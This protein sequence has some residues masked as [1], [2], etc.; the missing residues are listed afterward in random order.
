MA[1]SRGQSKK[2]GNRKP[3]HENGEGSDQEKITST[4]TVKRSKKNSGP[5]EPKIAKTNSDTT[6]R[7]HD[8]PP[9]DFR[10]SIQRFP[11]WA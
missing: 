3:R 4:G 5:E 8:L 6:K 9:V 11:T 7:T 1:R 2:I 10:L